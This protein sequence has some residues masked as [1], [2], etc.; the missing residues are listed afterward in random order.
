M[1]RFVLDFGAEIELL[2]KGELDQSL[3]AAADIWREEARGV[4]FMR[5]YYLTPA[6][7]TSFTVT[8]SPNAGYV[9]VLTGVGVHLSAGG[10]A[11]G[12]G[13]IVSYGEDLSRPVGGASQ[14]GTTGVS[15][16]AFVPFARGQCVMRDGDK[17]TVKT[18]SG[19]LA[20]VSLTAIQIPE[21]RLGVILA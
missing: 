1:A 11:G 7:G 8:D 2:T 14:Q 9:W 17:L 10:V 12:V 5:R 20:T 16:S 21:E 4:K 6:G 13:V 18:G 3:S 15:D 19:A